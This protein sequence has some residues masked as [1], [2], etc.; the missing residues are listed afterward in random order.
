LKEKASTEE[1]SK[2]SFGN[3]NLQITNQEIPYLT[4]VVC[5]L[6]FEVSGL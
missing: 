3:F 5:S 4:F 6:N 2:R 1:L